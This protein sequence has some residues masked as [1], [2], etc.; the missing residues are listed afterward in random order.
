MHQR[1]VIESHCKLEGLIWDL[2]FK[3]YNNTCFIST[4][5]REWEWIRYSKYISFDFLKLRIIRVDRNLKSVLWTDSTISKLWP[6]FTMCN[7]VFFKWNAT[8]D[9]KIYLVLS[10]FCSKTSSKTSSK[11]VIRDNKLG[12]SVWCFDF[13]DSRLR[14]FENT[15][16]FGLPNIFCNVFVWLA[17]LPHVAGY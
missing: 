17:S 14:A 8:F 5:L 3:L 9:T 11:T 4:N 16:T 10:I 15:V 1:F 13:D 7:V 12:F 6:V 2:C